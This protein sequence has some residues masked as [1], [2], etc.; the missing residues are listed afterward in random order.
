MFIISCQ[1]PLFECKLQE[2]RD[3]P[4]LH[5]WVSDVSSIV[6]TQYWMNEWMTKIQRVEKLTVLSLL[7]IYFFHF[8]ENFKHHPGP[9]LEVGNCPMKE[10][11]CYISVF[12]G[13][14]FW[15]FLCTCKTLQND[16][17]YCVLWY[18]E[19]KLTWS[20][21]VSYCFPLRINWV[22]YKQLSN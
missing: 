22:P 18:I 3:L 16:R 6:G 4:F 2:G 11:G 14:E 15:M 10:R 12:P 19:V 7:F 17:D 20:S 5:C 13:L 8:I 1:F 9:V 21:R